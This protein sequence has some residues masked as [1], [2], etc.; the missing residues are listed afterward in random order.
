M[1]VLFPRLVRRMCVVAVGGAVMAFSAFLSASEATAQ[2]HARVAPQARYFP[3]PDGLAVTHSRRGHARR[4]DGY[5]TRHRVESGETLYRIALQYGTTVTALAEANGIADPREL[6]AGQLLIIPTPSARHDYTGSIDR[7]RPLPPKTHSHHYR[8]HHDSAYAVRRNRHRRHHREGRASAHGDFSRLFPVYGKHGSLRPQPSRLPELRQLGRR[9]V[10][11]P[12]GHYAFDSEMPAGYTFLGQFIDHDITLDLDSKLNDPVKVERLKNYRTP[13]LDLDS[14]YG[15][16]P[17]GSPHLYHLPYLRVGRRIHRYGHHSRYDLLRVHS[18]DWPGP[19]GGRTTGLIGDPRNDENFILAQLQA[20]FIAL[21]N[22]VV[23]LL[24][25]RHL[26]RDR[27]YYCGGPCSNAELAE[28]LPHKIKYRLFED[29]RQTVIHYY[30]RVI[31]EDFLPRLIGVE[32]TRDILLNGRD[33]YFPGGF[34]TPGGGVKRPF[35]P[36]E[37][38]AAAFRYGHSQVRDEYV[39]RRGVRHTLFDDDDFSREDEVS[40]FSTVTPDLLVDWRYF[41]DIDPVPP[42][43]FNYAR[44]IDPFVVPTLHHLGAAGVIG[45]RDFGS[46]PARNLMRGRLFHLPSGQAVA[47]KILPALQQ[48]GVLNM[49]HSGPR[50]KYAEKG[51]AWYAYWLEPDRRTREVLGRVGSPLWYYILQEAEVFGEPTGFGVHGDTHRVSRRHTRR[52]YAASRA[53]GKTRYMRH[54]SKH[55]HTLGPV[56]GTIVG[57]VL[58]GLVEHYGI[59]TGKGLAYRPEIGASADGE[60]G[61][62]TLTRVHAGDAD[63]GERYLMR[64]LLI[65]AGAVGPVRE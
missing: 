12:R 43:G 58:I 53:P 7:R 55:G 23:N 39:L 61:A 28:A 52:R 37:F 60:R 44:R 62:F 2:R 15:L 8:R 42:R 1:F 34:K 27:E 56:G 30:H 18:R 48:R 4:K 38:T 5:V 3:G 25:E 19:R 50:E 16:G 45:M 21:H 47:E 63:L 49:W 32:R 57:E 17:S 40:G 31:I 29:A 64:N 22:R 51:H 11:P 59:K 24:I 35:I 10:E 20:A 26:D 33:F 14:V 65:D 13:D 6:R 41:F 46:L 54:G 36:I 9:L